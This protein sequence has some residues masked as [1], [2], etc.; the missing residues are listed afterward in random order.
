MLTIIYQ[1]LMATLIVHNFPLARS[2]MRKTC[3]SIRG[4]TDAHSTKTSG[5]SVS[6]VLSIRFSESTY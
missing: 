5:S 2:N 1:R 3:G 6:Y 4:E